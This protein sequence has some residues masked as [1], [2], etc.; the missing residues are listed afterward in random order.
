MRLFFLSL[1][2]VSLTGCTLWHHETQSPQVQDSN[3]M[4]TFS[5]VEVDG[6]INVTLYTGDSHPRVVL[7]G[8]AAEK[9]RVKIVVKN[10]LLQI[11]KGKSTVNPGPIRAE[12]HARYLTDFTF[13]GKG[14]ITGKGIQSR[15][16]DITIDNDGQTQ[17]QGH[18]ALRNLT[19]KGSGHTQIEGLQGRIV[20]IKL[21]GSPHV[22]LSG[23]VEL[24]SLNLEGKGWFSL[25]WVKSNALKLWA[26]DDVFVQLAGRVQNL[27]IEL[28]NNAHFNGR[29]LRGISVFAKTHDC[30]TADISV[31]EKQHTLALDSSNIYF[32]NL[33]EMKADFMAYNGSVLDMREWES[34]F[35]KPYTRYN[36]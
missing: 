36:K 22:Q 21:A 35:L 14:V 33:P 9:S 15:L 23:V 25:Y 6:D 2:I 7:F 11:K 31:V 28:W 30:S 17:L 19:I 20:N 24:T 4:G 3:H 27:D 12:I 32:Y 5:R 1:I 10:G 8:D 29:Y 18:M 13:K 16:M 26:R 34:P